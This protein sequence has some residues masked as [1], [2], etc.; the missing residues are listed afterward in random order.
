M[1]VQLE[2][3]RFMPRIAPSLPVDAESTDPAY[4]MEHASENFIM[5]EVMLGTT[6]SESY[7]DFNAKDIQY[8]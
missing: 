7:A 4:A 3:V 8:G 6:T 2:T 1:D 5:C